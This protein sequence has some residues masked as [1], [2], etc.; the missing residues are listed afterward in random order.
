MT[1]ASSYPALR[2]E[3]AERLIGPH[4]W[5]ACVKELRRLYGEDVQIRVGKTKAKD[6]REDVDVFVNGLAWG[7]G[8]M[9]LESFVK[10]R[11]WR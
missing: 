8:L 4:R 2:D 11:Y 9:G 6:S 10:S 7:G 1:A 5:H 3:T